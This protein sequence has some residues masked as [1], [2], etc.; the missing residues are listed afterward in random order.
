MGKY[1]IFHRVSSIRRSSDIVT[2][3]HAQ[4]WFRQLSLHNYG[5]EVL[6]HSPYRPEQVLS[7]YQR[8]LSIAND[9]AGEIFASSEVRESRLSQYFANSVKSF[10]VS[11]I[12]ESPPKCQQFIK[13]NAAYLNKIVLNWLI[14]NMLNKTFNLMQ[15]QSTSIC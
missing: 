7:E 4:F 3:I 2:A 10:H 6:M 12:I 11:G 15:M 9:F 8:L 5:F 13:Q 14:P 1:A